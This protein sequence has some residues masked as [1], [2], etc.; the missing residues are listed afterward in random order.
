MG[1]TI[2]SYRIML[3]EELRKWKRFQ[4]MLRIDDRGI[5]ED[6]TDVCR[7]YASEAGN[8]ASPSKVEPM[9]LS[10]LFA[11]HK[12]L[13]QLQEKTQQMKKQRSVTSS[14]EESVV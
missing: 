13:K 8:L 7:R 14:E 9:F 1:R 5:F 10:I 11:H 12:T 3:E 2:L 6:M 4:D